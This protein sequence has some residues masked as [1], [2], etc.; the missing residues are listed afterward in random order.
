MRN[1]RLVLVAPLIVTQWKLQ[2]LSS[3]RLSVLTPNG[4]SLREVLNAIQVDQAASSL[5]TKTHRPV[6]VA[7]SFC[8][9]AVLADTAAEMSRCK[10]WTALSR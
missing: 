4:S 8:V 7:C 5:H 2:L 1:H 6:S 10:A 9:R 3:P